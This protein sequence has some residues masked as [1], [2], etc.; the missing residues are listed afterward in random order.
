MR[1]PARSTQLASLFVIWLSAKPAWGGV[2]DV[3][4]DPRFARLEL[5]PIAPVL[6][7]TVASTYPV[8]SASSSVAYVFNPALDTLACALT[9]HGFFYE[10][11]PR[12]S[13]SSP[14]VSPQP[15]RAGPARR[16]GTTHALRAVWHAG[17]VGLS[18]GALGRGT[19]LRCKPAHAVVRTQRG[20]PAAR[21]S[22]C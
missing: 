21:T 5:A 3:L 15:V 20:P 2:A 17:A 19:E 4:L 1:R 9:F 6:A 14:E 16:R 7:G 11:V 8:A 13:R 12:R 22:S 18:R 10:V